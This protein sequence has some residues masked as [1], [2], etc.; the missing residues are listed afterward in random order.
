MWKG[1]RDPFSIVSSLRVQPGFVRKVL[2]D[3]DELLNE[4][5]KSSAVDPTPEHVRET[6]GGSS[7][8]QEADEVA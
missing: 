7:A 1:G 8:G 4:W 5:K 2:K 6:R 3:Y